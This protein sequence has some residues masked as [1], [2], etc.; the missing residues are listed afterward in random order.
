MLPPVR[1]AGVSGSARGGPP[2]RPIHTC[3]NAHMVMKAT[4]LEQASARSASSRT[5]AQNRAVMAVSALGGL[6]I[7]SLSVP[8]TVTG[9]MMM[10]FLM[11]TAAGTIWQTESAKRVRFGIM[12]NTH[13]KKGHSMLIGGSVSQSSPGAAIRARTLW[14]VSPGDEHDPMLVHSR[15]KAKKQSRMLLICPADLRQSAV[16]TLTL[17]LTVS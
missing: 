8:C 2:R 14:K 12:M 15:G 5:S 6:A 1:D 17:M 16:P 11:T 9:L 7:A 3:S 4:T 13:R 10:Q